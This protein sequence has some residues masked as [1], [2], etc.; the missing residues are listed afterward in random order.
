MLTAY[1][2]RDIEIIPP[3]HSYG[4]CA[5][6]VN[7]QGPREGERFMAE[8]GIPA[9]ELLANLKREIDTLDAQGPEGIKGTPGWTWLLRPGSWEVCPAPGLNSHIKPV[10]APCN[11]DT[12]RRKAAK[13]ARRKAFAAEGHPSAG[14]LVQQLT[15]AGFEKAADRGRDTSGFRVVR[16]DLGEARRNPRRGVRVLWHT[17]GFLG[18]VD[19]RPGRCRE[20]ADFLTAK[21]K[22]AVHYS[23]G[24]RIEVLS[25]THGQ[26]TPQ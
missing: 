1:Q 2:G 12:C 20:I 19:A 7:G 24:A 25:K 13:E 10:G 23:G 11:E 5:F 9:A 16:G 26:R 15:R 18:P 8:H 21:D 17:A 3:R 6:T 4:R 22:Y 14:A